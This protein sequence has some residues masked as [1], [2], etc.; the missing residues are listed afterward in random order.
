MNHFEILQNTIRAITPVD[1]DA[2]ANA[3]ARLD[4]LTMPHWAL[5]QV[6][7]LAEQ[8][9]ALSGQMPPP[10]ARRTIVVMA[11]DHGV[12]EEGVS[13]YPQEVTGQMV[14]NFVGG[15]AGINAIAKVGNAKLLIV[16][17]G[18]KADLS[19]MT[20]NGSV[21][22]RKIALGTA[23]MAK[24]PAMSKEQALSA[25]V[26]GI[27]I[28]QNL[29]AGNDLIAAGEMGIGNTTSATAV[30]CAIK[31]VDPLD[32]TGCGTGIDEDARKLKAHVVRKSL[33]LNMPVATDAL[34]VLCK[35]GGFEIAGIV[36]L[37]LGVCAAK[38]A[39]VV[40]G[41]ICAA[42]A[43]LAQLFCPQVTSYMVAA[44]RS[45]ERGHS[46]MLEHLGLKPLL[47]LDFRLGEGT[48][49]AMSMPIFDAA[50]AMLT[51]VATFAE[52]GVS[53]K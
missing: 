19:S 4:R 3:R 20:A 35:V 26:A 30:L 23:N 33:A 11:G 9:S 21:L 36:G 29:A 52:A 34:D 31:G 14:A 22:D 10:V 42:A 40:D 47:Q 41:Y 1:V 28:A 2:R 43:M 45:V 16:D 50:R 12:A 24:G 25:I 15:G 44:H 49:A 51:D 18:V 8:L 37:Y 32:A 27:R 17:M 7:D 53:D 13:L 39:V 38:K 5:G 48:G 46:I 6:L